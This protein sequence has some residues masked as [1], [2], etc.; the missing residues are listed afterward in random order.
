MSRLFQSTAEEVEQL[1]DSVAVR[2]FPMSATNVRM[3][4]HCDIS[5]EDVDKVVKKI[6]FVIAELQTQNGGVKKPKLEVE[7]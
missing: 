7:G 2:M 3:V 6:K 1:N 5:R 4:L